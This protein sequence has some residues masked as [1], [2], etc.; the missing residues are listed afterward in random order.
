VSERQG[1]R[2]RFYRC[3]RKKSFNFLSVDSLIGCYH[4]YEDKQGDE[5]STSDMQKI[6]FN[7]KVEVEA[8]FQGINSVC[9]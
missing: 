8:R 3:K 5:M 4:R 1:D 6:D 2:L 7:R 9:G